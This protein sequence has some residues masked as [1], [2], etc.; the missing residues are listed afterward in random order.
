MRVVE[1]DGYTMLT[2]TLIGA[3]LCFAYLR[4]GGAITGVLILVRP[5]LS[6]FANTGPYRYTLQHRESVSASAC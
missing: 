2:L 4:R 1:R 3:G 6:L 5:G